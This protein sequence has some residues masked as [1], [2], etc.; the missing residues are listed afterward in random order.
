M[1]RI[2]FIVGILAISVS[3]AFAQIKTYADT[4]AIRKQI[5]YTLK[6]LNG[7]SV[8]DSLIDYVKSYFIFYDNIDELPP[9]RMYFKLGQPFNDVIYIPESTE[10]S[11]SW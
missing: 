4:V 10:G 6:H 9:D 8:P 11:K 7:K 5:V 2:L 3:G 1:H